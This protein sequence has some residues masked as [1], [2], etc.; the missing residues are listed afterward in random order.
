MDYRDYALSLVDDGL[1]GKQMLIHCLQYMSQDDV[2]D[3][4]S[5]NDYPAPGE[6]D[7]EITEDSYSSIPSRY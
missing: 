4:L 3:M 2:M 6:F 5:L 7:E 1:D